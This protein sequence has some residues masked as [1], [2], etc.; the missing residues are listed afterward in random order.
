MKP[1]FTA[2]PTAGNLPIDWTAV[3]SRLGLRLPTEYKNLASE[4]G[5]LDIGGYLWMHVPCVQEGRF[6]YGNWL[7]QTHRHCRSASGDQRP[8]FHPS[9]GGLLAWGMTRSAGYLFWDTAG[10]DDPDQWPV[11]LFDQDKANDGSDPWQRYDLPFAEMLSLMITTGLPPHGALQPIARRTAFLPNP[12]P[13]P[14][15]PPPPPAEDPVRR[16]ALTVGSGL[17]ALRH[18]VPPPDHPYLGDGSWDEVFGQ[19]GSRLPTE[20]IQLMKTYGCGIWSSW[21]RFVPPLRTDRPVPRPGGFHGLMQHATEINDIYRDLRTAH[22]E[23]QP[24]AVWPEPDG[25]FA[26]ADSIDGDA[27]GWLTIGEPDDW[28]LIVYPRHYDQGPPLTGN[29]V[30]TL[31][32]WLRGREAP[33]CF[34]VLDEDDDPLE[35]ATFGSWR[36]AS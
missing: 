32:E 17:D 2:L 18:L 21:L 26:F 31:L 11:V 23:F 12:G 34:Q 16:T 33:E 36:P 1:P 25:F 14:P 24:L 22:P 30:D 10:S 8:P 9:R 13:W 15:P 27:L 20:Y 28:P 29:L 19:L 35:F 4:F 5:P 6:D 3:E 7:K